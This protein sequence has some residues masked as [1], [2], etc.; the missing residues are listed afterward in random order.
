MFDSIPIETRIYPKDSL[1]SVFDSFSNIQEDTKN[2]RRVIGVRIQKLRGNFTPEEREV[3]RIE[4]MKK[5]KEKKQKLA[6]NNN[7][8]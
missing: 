5:Q 6:L 2:S 3:K 1:T 7:I 4:S 8:S